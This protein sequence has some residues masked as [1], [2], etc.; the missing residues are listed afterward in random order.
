M[1]AN[2]E[3][4]TQEKK[5]MEEKGYLSKVCYINASQYFIWTDE[6]VEFVASLL[7]RQIRGEVKQLFLYLPFPNFLQL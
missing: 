6:N 5:L 7:F 1:G 2:C 4:V 3:E